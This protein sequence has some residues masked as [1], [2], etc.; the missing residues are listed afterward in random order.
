[1]I[2]NCA[3]PSYNF[4]SA[5]KNSSKE[6]FFHVFPS[7]HPPTEQIPLKMSVHFQITITVCKNWSKCVTCSPSTRDCGGMWGNLVP[8]GIVISFFD[9]AEQS[10]YIKVLI[11]WLWE[12]HSV[13]RGLVAPQFFGRLKRALEL[14]IFV[15]MIPLVTI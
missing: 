10:G 15:R 12:K 5:I 8:K 2:E 11:C 7:P 3:P 4:S 13:E 6:G 9:Y 1:M 14:L